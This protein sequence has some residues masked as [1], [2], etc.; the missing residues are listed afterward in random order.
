MKIL[1]VTPHY[2]PEGFSVTA[3]CEAWAKD[4]ND[5]LVVTNKPNYGFGRIL[6]EYRHV[7]DEVISGVRVHR[8]GCF[9]RKDSRLSIIANYLSFYW[10]AKH[11]LSH[12]KED[13]DVVYSFSLSPVIAVSGANV[14]ARKHRIRHVLHCLDLWPESVLATGAM[15]SRS[16]GYLILYRWSKKV[17]SKA[18]EIL[19]SSPSFKNYFEQVLKLPSDNIHFVPQPPFLAEKCGEDFEYPCKNP[20]I[21]AGNIGLLQLLEPL[22]EAFCDLPNKV[23]A[24][25]FIIGMGSRQKQIEALIKEKNRPDRV[26]YL[27]RKPR[28]ETAR[29]YANASAVIVSLS[30]K[31]HVGQTIP[32]K[33]NSSL[34]YG[35]PIFGIIQGDGKNVIEQAGGGVVSKGEDASSIKDALLGFI[36]L[37]EEEKQRMGEANKKCFDENFSFSSCMKQVTAH[38]KKQESR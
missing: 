37:P 35:R 36:A 13:F 28:K 38:L 6:P 21:Y 12:L 4:G 16:L 3:M 31:G 29:Y 1:V 11:Y 24:R 30:N 26:V 27:G 20:F 18:S 9:P 33:L 15:S 32:N 22:I 17:Y 2:Y 7:N 10:T 25:L 8:C 5:V 14:Y 34:F 23:E 19:V